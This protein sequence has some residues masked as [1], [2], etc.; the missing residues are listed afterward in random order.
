MGAYKNAME[1]LVEEEVAR[2]ISGLSSRVASYINQVELVAYALNQLPSLYATSEKGLEYQLSRGRSKFG[3]QV[4]QAVKRSLVAIQRDPLRTYVPLQPQQSP[5]MR[6]VL[7][8]LRLLLKNDQLNWENLPIAVQKVILT[9]RSAERTSPVTGRPVNPR[10]A[11]YGYR[12]IPQAPPA[13]AAPPTPPPPQ[14]PASRVPPSP[15]RPAAQRTYGTAATDQ[16]WGA[17]SGY[18][19][20]YNPVMN[21][22]AKSVRRPPTP[23]GQPANSE[24]PAP[25]LPP[26]P[27]PQEQS[28][29]FY[30]WDDPLYKV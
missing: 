4:R 3:E 24:Q 2:Q 1:V 16:T 5:Q 27:E 13:A 28:A 14:A 15:A 6:E 26:T 10:L 20:P 17:P 11:Q 12:A 30:G 9:T 25:P 29:D 18:A 22:P 8:Q 19:G 23:P 7:H 21:T